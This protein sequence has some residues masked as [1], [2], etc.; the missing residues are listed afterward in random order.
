MG[1]STGKNTAPYQT[2]FFNELNWSALVPSTQPVSYNIY[3]D[4]VL[5]KNI[6]ANSFS[7]RD[8]NLLAETTYSYVVYAVDNNG[9][10]LNIG[11]AL[12]TTQK[13]SKN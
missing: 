10:E 1:S 11:N 5:I 13:N 2:E 9:D 12:V 6:E 7:Y 8:H 4:D 3:R